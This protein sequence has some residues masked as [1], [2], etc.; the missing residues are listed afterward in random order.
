MKLAQI[1]AL[2][3]NLPNPALDK[4][5]FSSKMLISHAVKMVKVASSS[6]YQ[7]LLLGLILSKRAKPL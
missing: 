3:Q 6:T 7:M 2:K 5:N 4:R 1:K